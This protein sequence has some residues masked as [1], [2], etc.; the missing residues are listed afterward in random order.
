MADRSE[1]AIVLLVLAAAG[2][3]LAAPVLGR[4]GA[5]ALADA[6]MWLAAA[7]GASAFAVAARSTVRAARRDRAD[8]ARE[9]GP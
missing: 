1:T 4:L 8:G 3:V 9:G 2:A 7:C 5:P 6:A